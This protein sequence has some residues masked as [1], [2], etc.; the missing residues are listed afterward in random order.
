MIKFLINM[1]FKSHGECR[2]TTATKA[3]S[4][5]F[6]FS[7][8]FQK[9]SPYTATY[10]KKYAKE[11][12]CI[13]DRYGTPFDSIVSRF[14]L[15]AW[16][17]GFIERLRQ[18]SFP[19]IP[20]QCQPWGGKRLGDTPFK[21]NDFVGVFVLFSGGCLLAIFVFFTEFSTFRKIISDNEII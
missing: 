7:F 8:A 4:Y 15:R 6:T 18:K 20:R 12:Y 10:N 3:L 14:M 17:N 1:D 2:M 13:Y 16:E 11:C 5:F 21:L 19:P 9:N